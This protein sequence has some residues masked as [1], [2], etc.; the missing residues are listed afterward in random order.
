MIDFLVQ[1]DEMHLES[2]IDEINFYATTITP[3]I[4][5]T[6]LSVQNWGFVANNNSVLCTTPVGY[7]NAPSYQM[8]IVWKK[9]FHISFANALETVKRFLCIRRPS[10]RG[11]FLYRR[12][13]ST[14]RCFCSAFRKL[15]RQ[16]STLVF[17]LLFVLVI[18]PL[19]DKTT[20]ITIY[21]FLVPGIPTN[22]RC[23]C[24]QP[25]SCYFDKY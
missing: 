4:R 18:I 11:E 15:H 7:T 22:H 23:F 14:F 6:Y 24:S 13:S 9:V 19:K 16:Q 1:R 10:G 8:R 20:M 21:T 2:V 25:Q 3:T 12:T 5:C 17:R